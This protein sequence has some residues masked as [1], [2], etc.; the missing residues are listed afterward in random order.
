LILGDAISQAV[1]TTT[2]TSY[3]NPTFGSSYQ[4]NIPVTAVTGTNPTLDVTIEESDDSGTNNIRVY[5]F[6]RITAVGMYRSPVLPLV[7][8]RIRYVQTVG[9]SSPSFTRSINR[10]QSS[11]NAD[12]LRQLIDRTIV[13]T[14]LNS[15]TPA[16]Y[17]ADVGNQV[18]LVVNIGAATTPPILQLEGSDDNQQTW[19]SIGST[20]TTVANSTVALNASGQHWQWIRARVSTAGVG[21]TAGYVLI[22]AHD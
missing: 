5:D 22:K 16:M 6:P 17:V 3:L 18:K 1:T 19:T 12:M 20:L 2:T 4:I 13:L 21:V 8:N 14:T 7:G 11:Y 15:A 10:L 9:G